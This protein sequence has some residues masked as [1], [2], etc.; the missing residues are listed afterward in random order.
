MVN[1]NVFNLRPD[2]LLEFFDLFLF[3]IVNVPE[4]LVD[5]GVQVIWLIVI[6]IL[7]IVIISGL[8]IIKA[9]LQV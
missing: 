7:I 8:S 1:L 5:L 6:G 9:L 4:K 2:F 3:L